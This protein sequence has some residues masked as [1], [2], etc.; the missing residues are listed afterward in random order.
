MLKRIVFQRW[1]PL[2]SQLQPCW[3]LHPHPCQ[4]TRARGEAE[5]GHS[6]EYHLFV[7]I[8][9][10]IGKAPF[11]SL[12][13]STKSFQCMSPCH[14]YLFLP[15]LQKICDSYERSVYF[16]DI[17]QGI[18]DTQDNMDEYSS[19]GD[20]LTTLRYTRLAFGNPYL[21]FNPPMVSREVAE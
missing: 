3:L 19:H 4:H 14:I 10:C 20:F 13:D 1:L 2:P 5:R 15:Q 17:A 18:K 12:I 16:E 8:I 9:Y 21:N 11:P 7:V 6:S